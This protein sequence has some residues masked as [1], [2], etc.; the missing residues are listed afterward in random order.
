IGEVTS[1]RAYWVNG[2]PIWHRGDNGSTDLERQIRNRYHY[3]WLC[4][5]HINEQHVHNIDVCN[6]IAGGHPIKA[7]GMGARQQ[8]GN[9]SGE[10]WDNF[11]VEYQYANGMRFHAYCGQITRE[12]SSISEAVH[13]AKGMAEFFDGKNTIKLNNGKSWR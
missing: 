10:I 12:W 8:L 13:G 9:K 1:L 3:I 11:A 6:W 7:W 2:Q 5:D 4:G